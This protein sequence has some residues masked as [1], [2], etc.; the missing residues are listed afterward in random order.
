M[1]TLATKAVSQLGQRSF[2]FYPDIK[3]T[4]VKLL[5]FE[6]SFFF[7]SFETF[8]LYLKAIFHEN[9]I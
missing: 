3:L 7:D 6:N 9:T 2:T 5:G 8:E 1:L 4:F